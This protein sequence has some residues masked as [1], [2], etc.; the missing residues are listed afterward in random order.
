[1]KKRLIMTTVVILVA[2]IPYLYIRYYKPTI[3]DDLRQTLVWDMI[4]YFSIRTSPVLDPSFIDEIIGY[5]GFRYSLKNIE[6]VNDERADSIEQMLCLKIQ[7]V[8]RI[9]EKSSVYS[10]GSPTEYF[11]ISCLENRQ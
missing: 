8:Y 7:V 3:P 9:P 5:Q 6:N 11:F 2:L 10:L 1:M 4:P